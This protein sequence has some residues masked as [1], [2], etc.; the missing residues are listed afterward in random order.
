MLACD[1][2]ALPNGASDSS[3]RL[4]AFDAVDELSHFPFDP[5]LE[6]EQPLTNQLGCASALRLWH[7][8]W[9]GVLTEA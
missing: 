9:L 7:A 8:D 3:L 6:R 1:C 4:D 2:F 5:R